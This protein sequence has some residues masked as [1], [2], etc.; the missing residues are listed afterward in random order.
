MNFIAID[1]AA[2]GIQI[3]RLQDTNIVVPWHQIIQTLITNGYLQ[4]PAGG[5][6]NSATSAVGLGHEVHNW[7]VDN[8]AI[9]DLWFTNFR[10]E[11]I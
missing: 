1:G 4:A 2:V 7:S 8:S 10:V 11:S 6:Q 3:P 9:V 5:W